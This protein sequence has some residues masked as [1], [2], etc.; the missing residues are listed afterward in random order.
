MTLG[1]GTFYSKSSKQKLNRKS[2]TESELVAASDMSGQIMWTMEFAQ[3]QGIKVK[4]IEVNQDNE[5]AQKLETNGQLSSGKITRHI[6]IWYFFIKDKVDKGD[7]K[8]IHCPTGE[9]IADYFTKP[10]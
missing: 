8:I 6:N 3:C 2:S 7:F 1:S 4:W 5:S 9:M 10:L